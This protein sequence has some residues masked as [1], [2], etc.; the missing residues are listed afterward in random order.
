M[1]INNPENNSL[2]SFG[3]WDNFDEGD[4]FAEAEQEE[5]SLDPNDTEA[6]IAQVNKDEVS[7]ETDPKHEE[8]TVEDFF[9][10]VSENEEQE[11]DGEEE[12]SDVSNISALTILKNRGLVE[13]ELEEGEE[14]T[15]ERAEEL[16]EDKFEDQIDKRV[17]DLFS[18]M[19]DVVKQIN[20][21]VLKGGD[22]NEFFNN[23]KNSSTQNSLTEDIDLEQ[24][25]NQELVLRT[26]L[27]EEGEYDEEYIEGQIEWLK[28]SG[29]LKAFSEKKFEKWKE[30]QK[31]LIKLKLKKQEDFYEAQ[32]K[33]T[34]EAKK[35][36]NDYFKNNKNI[37]GLTYSKEDA[38]NTSSFIN[39]KSIKLQN[40][41]N[42]TEMQKVMF[43]DLPKSEV[44]MMQLA[45]L[46]QNRNEDGSFNF[47][48]FLN[49]AETKAT[50]NLK[51]NIR[52]NSNN[53]PNNST[54][55]SSNKRTNKSLADFFGD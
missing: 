55:T 6:I 36:V 52:R 1:N 12:E 49:A 22:I 17:E 54:S 50:R 46:L 24:E 35:R 9:S 26:L 25:S 32:K 21:F 39:D 51:Q 31:N 34:R 3:G 48:P 10:D 23:I 44:A 13:Y 41:N 4:F 7:S 37:G 42:I 38:K 8:E 15:E 20:K 47:E 18:N 53:T 2:D 5:A 19:P 45:V 30:A 33:A 11:N 28:D 29:K 27:S 14:L 43:Y 16:I 40:G